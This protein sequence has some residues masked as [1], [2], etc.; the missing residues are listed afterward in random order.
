MDDKWMTTD[1]K[2]RN[3]IVPEYNCLL[4]DYISSRKNDYTKHLSTNKH[5]W[6]TTQYHR[7]TQLAKVAEMSQEK[8]Q[9]QYECKICDY[10]TSRKNDYDKH[11]LTSK[12]NLRQKMK[13]S[14]IPKKNTIP[15]LPDEQ[16]NKN[17]SCDCGKSYKFRQG[18]YNHKKKCKVIHQDD[19]NNTNNKND[20]T[21]NKIDN[22]TYFKELFMKVF[23]QNNNIQNTIV[24][25]NKQLINMTRTTNTNNTN[26]IHTNNSHYK[27][28]NNYNINLF[29][30]E[31]CKN[32][33]NMSDFIKNIEIG[34]NDLRITGEK[35]LVEGITNL[36][37]TNLN[38]MPISNRPIWCSD[39]K[40]KRIFIKDEDIWEEDE[41]NNKTKE[42]IVNISKIQSK[43]VNKYIEKNPN[44]IQ[45][46]KQKDTYITIVKH[47][48]DDIKDKK[49]KVI[50]KLINDIHLT[51]EKMENIE[52]IEN[53][54]NTENT[55]NIVN[56]E[57]K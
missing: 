10:I 13:N 20:D 44:W 53:T 39:K 48:T 47:S 12:H 9:K 31:N 42:A 54:E 6:I 19:T 5:K 7:I 15:L 2:N 27:I 3:S 16:N 29:L 56:I 8:N 26:I 49:D 25:Q 57:N 22:E 11:L 36:V 50:D 51:E 24:E 46:D 14:S 55:E 34:I 52:N 33:I 41:N 4:C 17:Y 30:N 40:R 18:L 37:I 43:N 35:G 1:A 28:K 45:N 21:N 38:K 32:A 23:E